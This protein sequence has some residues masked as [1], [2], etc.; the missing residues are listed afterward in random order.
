[1][2]QVSLQYYLLTFLL[3]FPLLVTAGETLQLTED[4]LVSSVEKAVADA[5]VAGR[6]AMLA[7]PELAPAVSPQC[8]LPATAAS[9]ELSD[10]PTQ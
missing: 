7:L 9:S 8:A 1:M 5:P 10:H 6:S 4:F 2:K 3:L